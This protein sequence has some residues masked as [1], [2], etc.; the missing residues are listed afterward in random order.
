MSWKDLPHDKHIQLALDYKD[1]KPLDATA[2]QLNIKTTSLDRRVRFFIEDANELAPWVLT[3]TTTIEEAAQEFASKPLPDFLQSTGNIP[4]LTDIHSIDA[5]TDQSTWLAWLGTM[6]RT[7]RHITVMHLC[8]IHFPN[9]DPRALELTFQIIRDVQ[10]D[11]IVV[12]SDAADF[13]LISS[14]KPD[15]DIE[16]ETDVLDAFSS[17]WTPFIHRLK[18]EAPA[19]KLVY[20]LGNHD[21]RIYTYVEQNSRYTRVTVL[22]RFVEIV[23]CGG[24]VWWIGDVDHVRVGPLVVMHG[25]RYNVHA[26]TSVLGDFGHQVCVMFGHIHRLTSAAK[27]GEDFSAQAV[28]SGCLCYPPLY[29][30]HGRPIQKQQQGTA[31]A[32]VDLGGRNVQFNNLLF[33]SSN[34]STW[35]RFER[36]LYVSS[37][38]PQILQQAI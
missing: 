30:K 22:R 20:I 26:A 25:N 5:N 7:K 8:D 21:R 12:G 34:D 13:S 23:R 37:D 11:L 18:R 38:E 28:S 10:P 1:G 2:N 32:D 24:A 4:R 35:V 9:H 15:P 27:A 33:N 3:K 31:I 16:S 6:Q 17:F 36:R 19:A 14:F 29:V